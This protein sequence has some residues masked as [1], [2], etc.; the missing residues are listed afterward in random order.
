[1]DILAHLIAETGSDFLQFHAAALAIFRQRF[2]RHGDLRAV[3]LVF[4][5][6]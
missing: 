3:D 5:H 6:E 2:E 4:L 1:M